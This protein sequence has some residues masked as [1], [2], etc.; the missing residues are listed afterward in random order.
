MSLHLF[1]VPREQSQS[2]SSS[3]YPDELRLL[4]AYEYGGVI[5]RRYARPDKEKSVEGAGWEIVCTVKLHVES[6]T[7]YHLKAVSSLII[8]S[9]GYES[10]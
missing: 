1:T 3:A 10:L 9:N 2:A 7:S 5:L 6:S 4:C 8:A